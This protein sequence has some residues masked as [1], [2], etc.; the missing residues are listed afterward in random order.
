[1]QR[2]GIN[3]GHLTQ[4]TGEA[5]KDQESFPKRPDTPVR[6]DTEVVGWYKGKRECWAG[7]IAQTKTWG[8]VGAWCFEGIARGSVFSGSLHGCG[9]R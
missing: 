6:L 2:I 3:E 8:W 4:L 9:G 7:R 5:R 1:M